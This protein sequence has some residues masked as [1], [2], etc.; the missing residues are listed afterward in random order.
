VDGVQGAC[1]AVHRE[2]PGG[3]EARV[4]A[5]AR[6]AGGEVRSPAGVHRRAQAQHR[7]RRG[8]VPQHRRGT[9]ADQMTDA[10]LRVTPIASVPAREPRP[11]ID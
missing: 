11:S 7:L 6:C 4:A 5:A 1:G 2:G 3:E 10:P 9:R 8:T